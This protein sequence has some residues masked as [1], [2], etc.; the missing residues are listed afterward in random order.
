MGP[1]DLDQ[2]LVL[3]PVLVQPLELEASR[4]ER[5]RRRIAQSADRCRALAREVDQVFGQRP[6]DSVPPCINLADVTRLLQRR[7]DY[8]AGGGVDDGGNTP[9]LSVERVLAGRFAGAFADGFVHS[10]AGGFFHGLS[11]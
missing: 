11:S 4:A 3:G 8:A 5:A 9:R 7:F 2:A 1:E 10:L 6:D